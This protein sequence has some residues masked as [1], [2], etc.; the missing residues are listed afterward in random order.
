VI[1]LNL[2]TT[3]MPRDLVRLACL[4][5]IELRVVAMRACEAFLSCCSEKIGCVNGLFS[6]FGLQYAQFISFA[7]LVYTYV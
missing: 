6:L 4:C 5:A 7:M 2:I 1:C 3:P